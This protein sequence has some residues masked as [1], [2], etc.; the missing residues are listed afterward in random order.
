MEY[1]LDRRLLVNSIDL[2]E[3]RDSLDRRSLVNSK[4]LYEASDGLDR[5]SL[6]NSMDLCEAS[7]GLLLLHGRRHPKAS[8]EV[9]Y[10][11]IRG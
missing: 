10:E 1:N 5:R 3:A 6:V 7:D 2:C 4:N 8:P 9:T 11:A